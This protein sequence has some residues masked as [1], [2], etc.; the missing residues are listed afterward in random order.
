MYKYSSIDESWI[1]QHLLQPYWSYVT[2]F[3]PLWMAPNLITMIGF[4]FVI[5]NFGLLLVFTPTLSEPGSAP[6]FLSYAIGLWLYST[7]D[8][9]DGK[10]ARRTNSSSPLGE[11]FDHAIDALN[12]TFGALLQ[13]SGMTLGLS[14]WT[15]TTVL[16]ASSTFYL[17][18]W[19]TYYTG[20]L[21]LGFINGPTEGLLISIGGL[22]AS[23]FY[24]PHI[25]KTTLASLVTIAFPSKLHFLQNAEIGQIALSLMLLLFFTTQLPVNLRRVHNVCVMKGLCFTEALFNVIP[26]LLITTSLLI[27]MQNE[28][29]LGLS[30]PLLLSFGITC[31]RMNVSDVVH[32]SCHGT[33]LTFRRL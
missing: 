9:V 18:T 17:A 20:T 28:T 29:A 25:W 1:A 30:I 7:F 3:F 22:L 33:I 2:T 11:L 14:V 12:C 8:N 32:L 21:Y 16:I 4:L 13:S 31:G 5:F 19:E 15:Y 23:A 26:Y 27:W 24:G 6:L 10:Q